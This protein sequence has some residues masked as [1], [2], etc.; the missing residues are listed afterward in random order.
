MPVGASAGL[1]RVLAGHG[2]LPRGCEGAIDLQLGAVER[3]G[4]HGLEE[5]SPTRIVS[6]HAVPLA[7][8]TSRGA[9]TTCQVSTS[10]PTFQCATALDFA[11]SK[12]TA[13]AGQYMAGLAIDTSM[14]PAP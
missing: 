3:A 9:T 2:L 14:A 8:S 10:S 7:G 1:K 13:F 5:N 6:G 12:V 4:A 11:W